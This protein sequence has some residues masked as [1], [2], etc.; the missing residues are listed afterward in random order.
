MRLIKPHKLKGEIT[1]KKILDAFKI[2]VRKHGYT[3]V[4]IQD[5]AREAKLENSN[6][7]Y[8]FENKETLL[9][10]AVKRE[11]ERLYK[12]LSKISKYRY[13]NKINE[14]A[15]FFFCESDKGIESAN[16]FFEI[17][18]PCMKNKAL[19]D[20]RNEIDETCKAIIGKI[21]RQYTATESSSNQIATFAYEYMI[22]KRLMAALSLEN[23]L[24]DQKN[25][26]RDALKEALSII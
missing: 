18:D 21:L 3:R 10:E 1:K 16:F 14:L 22:G 24:N 12:E 4:R 25:I 9:K 2:C 7:Y 15:E 20:L 23:N 5:I 8:Y 13:K 26:Y 6:I 19:N 17:L 11:A